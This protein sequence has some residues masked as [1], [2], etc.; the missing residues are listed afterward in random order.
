MLNLLQELGFSLVCIHWIETCLSYP[1][2]L[3]K[4]NGKSKGFFA[5]KKDIGQRDVLSPHCFVL[6]MEVLSQLLNKAVVHNEIKFHLGCARLGLTYFYFVDDLMK[7]TEA[8]KDTLQGII[9]VIEKFYTMY[10]LKVSFQKSDIFCSYVSEEEQQ[11]LASLMEF[12]KGRLPVRYLGVLLISG[13][14]KDTDC[15]S[16]IDGIT[17]KIKSRT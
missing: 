11:E 4:V 7:F 8:S 2:Y 14:L 16:L 6:C 1:M 3:I 15:K 9:S 10:G 17:T 5:R 12:R 13:K